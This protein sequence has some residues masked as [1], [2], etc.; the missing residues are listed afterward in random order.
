MIIDSQSLTVC[1]LAE[2]QGSW[3]DALIGCGK[4]LH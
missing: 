3:L 1:S 4:I 2:L